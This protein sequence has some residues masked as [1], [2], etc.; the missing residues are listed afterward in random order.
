V[1]NVNCNKKVVTR[2]QKKSKRSADRVNPNFTAS[3]NSR[4][5][6]QSAAEARDQRDGLVWFK[7]PQE[8]GASMEALYEMA[9]RSA[10]MR[11]TEEAVSPRM[12]DA[13]VQETL[14]LL[15]ERVGIRYTPA[16][17]QSIWRVEMTLEDYEA[18]MKHQGCTNCVWTF[19]AAVPL[20]VAALSR[21]LNPFKVYGNLDRI[22]ITI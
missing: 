18:V 6:A 2:E 15:P 20:V 22:L 12:V 1:D 8:D 14:R 17:G 3:S 10:P 13:L 5:R 11:Q 4:F 16:V 7:A 9:R 19:M 21:V